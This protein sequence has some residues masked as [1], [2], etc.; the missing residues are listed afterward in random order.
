MKLKTPI[1]AAVLFILFCAP[2]FGEGLRVISLAPSITETLFAIGLTKA[3]IVGVTDY[4]NYPAE[5]NEVLRVGSLSAVNIEKIVSLNPSHVFST[6]G[7]LNS[8]NARLKAAGLKVV[9]VDPQDISSTMKSIL[10][11][12]MILGKDKEARA[13]VEKMSAALARIDKRMAGIK[14]KKKVYFEI[15]D[16]PLTSCGKGS[17]QD[18]VLKRAG[19]VNIIGNVDVPYPSINQEWVIKEDPDVI[20]LGYMSRTDNNAVK[21]IVN[22]FGWQGIKAVRTGCI[23]WDLD[24]DALLRPG[25]R[26]AQAAEELQKRLY[27]RE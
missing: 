22:R 19:A 20:I 2:A 14:N 15:W 5:A 25:P 8:L 18:E 1:T 26:I 16:D 21:N 7:N 13:V 9:V 3:E 12:G 4:C 23:I 6:G 17:M 24:P 27:G 10:E 11:I